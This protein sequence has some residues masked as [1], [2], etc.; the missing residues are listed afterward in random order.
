MNRIKF[1]KITLKG[2]VLV[3]LGFL[4]L[5]GIVLTPV[6]MIFQYIKL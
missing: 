2:V 1:P 4:T 6:M 3:L 5:A